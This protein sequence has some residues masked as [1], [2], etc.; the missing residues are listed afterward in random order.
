MPAVYGSYASTV[1]VDPVHGSNGIPAESN[2]LGAASLHQSVPGGQSSAIE[3]MTSR[4][5]LWIGSS[6]SSPFSPLP[7]SSSAA[8]SSAVAKGEL[9]HAHLEDDDAPL[10]TRGGSESRKVMDSVSRDCGGLDATAR[11]TRG[12]QETSARGAS[13]LQHGP[14]LKRVLPPVTCR[15]AR[16]VAA[17]KAGIPRAIRSARTMSPADEEQVGAEGSR[18]SRRGREQSRMRSSAQFADP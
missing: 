9:S 3:S 13:R 16:V 11:K 17:R 2:D 15:R 1:T 18:R 10:A 8:C 4:T 14:E 12:G 6:F 7:S 5:S